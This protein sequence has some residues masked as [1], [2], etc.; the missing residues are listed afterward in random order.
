MT[1]GQPRNHGCRIS[2]AWTVE[3]MRTI[4]LENELLR[5]VVL[6]D[7]GSD[8]VEFRYK[9]HDLD[10]LF[11]SPNGL[12][13]PYRAMPSAPT[14]SPFIDYYSGGWNEIVPN[15]GPHAVHQGAEHGQHGE[16]SLIPWEYALVEDS[17]ERVVVRLWVRPLRTPLFLEKTLSLMP[18]QA[19][20]NIEERL[21][22]EGGETLDVMWG[23]HIA[24]GRP[25]LDEGAVIT[26]PAQ[27]L[28]VHESIPGYEP[29]RF[30]PE[31]DVRWPYVA[32][33]DGTPTDARLVP[34]VGAA[35]AQ[36]MAYLTSME[37]GW[38]AITN[39][40][41]RVGFGIQFDP[42][43]YRYVWYWQ[44]LGNV[45]SGY[46]WWSR[47]HTI[48]LE[49]WTSYPTSGLAQAVANGTAL[50]LEPGEPISTRLSAFAYEGLRSVSAVTADGQVRGEA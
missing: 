45:A 26:S 6:V 41:R 15:G 49:P 42:K 8:I 27:R 12:R 47:T 9:P 24:F 33:P 11:L 13:N 2:D 17:P 36:E 16:V 21:T 48:A 19:R 30:Q 43:L 1:L 31:A 34:A 50:K 37:E 25:F 5:V 46:P 32:A 40:V 20:L 23:Q 3:G 35:S 10:F 29:R 4:I 44:Q 7:K 18:G 39:P 28:L 22:N 14:A 38:Y